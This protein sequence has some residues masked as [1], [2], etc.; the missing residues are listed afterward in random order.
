M[1]RL[2]LVA[3]EGFEPF[4]FTAYETVEP[5][6]L[7]SRAD[8]IFGGEGEIRT[9][10]VLFTRQ[11]LSETVKLLRQ[12]KNCGERTRTFNLRFMRPTLSSR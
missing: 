2:K 1:P 6:L 10:I 4:R 5:P 3:G 8:K 12:L 9:R 11:T 7:H